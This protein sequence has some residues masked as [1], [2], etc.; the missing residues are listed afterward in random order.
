MRSSVSSARHDDR[1]LRDDPAVIE[2]Q[3]LRDDRIERD[4]VIDLVVDLH[5]LL[6]D[7]DRVREDHVAPHQGGEDLGDARLSVAGRAEEEDRLT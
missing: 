4:A 6:V 7:L 2:A 5:D 1:T 3:A